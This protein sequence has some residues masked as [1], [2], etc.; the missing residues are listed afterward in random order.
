[1]AK[2]RVFVSS[3][4]YD[5][6]QVRSDLEQFIKSMGY[7]P[8]LFEKGN[9]T[10][11]KEKKLEHYCYEEVGNADI[12]V[13]IVGGKFGSESEQGGSIT[14]TEL[15]TAHESGKLVYIFVDRNVLTEYRTWLNN[16]GKDVN[17][18][19]VDNTAIY[20]FLEEVYKFQNNNQIIGF[21]N[22]LE[23]VSYLKEQWSGLFQSFL[24][25]YSKKEEIN[26]AKQLK[27]QIDLL[28]DIVNYLKNNSKGK[29]K[30]IDDFVYINNKFLN[31]LKEKLEITD[32]NIY[33]R[34]LN[35]LKN[36][37]KMKLYKRVTTINQKKENESEKKDFYVWCKADVGEHKIL[38][39]PKIYFDSETNLLSQD[40]DKLFLEY[41]PELH[42]NI[43][44]GYDSFTIGI[45]A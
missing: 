7:E 14:Q 29:G 12:V 6:K 1:M 40:I 21:E 36:I 17:Y 22:S 16:K 41:S 42:E 43:P 35:D 25:E 33:I 31:W 20:K 28:G 9:V 23:I 3:T 13:C 8:I 11:G 39:I 2:T 32:Y 10:Y 44:S 34:D 30:V 37:L 27:G 24:R 15:K 5:L 45:Q 18:S 4:Y 38:E 26:L 19:Y